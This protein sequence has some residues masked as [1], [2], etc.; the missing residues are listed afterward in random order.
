[1][2]FLTCV[3]SDENG[4]RC[5]VYT[6]NRV[7]NNIPWGDHLANILNLCC[8]R[9]L[10]SPRFFSH[11]FSSPQYFLKFKLYLSS[12]KTLPTPLVLLEGSFNLG[13]QSCQGWLPKVNRFISR[14]DMVMRRVAS[15]GSWIWKC[16]FSNVNSSPH[17]HSIASHRPLQWLL[18]MPNHKWAEFGDQEPRCLWTCPSSRCSERSH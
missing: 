13:L 15:E 17:Y 7:D 14:T 12:S 16:I 9:I 2:Q 10:Q 8:Y 6:L 11:H 3:R 5:L 4:K 1:M 18:F